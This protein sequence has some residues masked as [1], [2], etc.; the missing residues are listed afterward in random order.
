MSVVQP[1]PGSFRDPGG[2]V[3]QIDSRVFK[4]VSEWFL[5]DFDFIHS[6]GLFKEFLANGLDLPAE[7]HSSNIPGSLDIKA[8]YVLETSKLSFI[9]FP[10]EWSFS[11]L[12]AAVHQ[13]LTIHLQALEIG[14]TLSDASVSNIQFQGVQAVFIDHVSSRP[15]RAEKLCEGHRRFCGQLLNHFLPDL[16]DGPLPCTGMDG[17]Q[18]RDRDNGAEFCKNLRPLSGDLHSL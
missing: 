10:Y 1:L 7:I 3:Y 14:L 5:G 11:A 4:T 15:Y 12:K 18:E 2:N 8:K 17:R 13:H 6:T 16:P 9:F